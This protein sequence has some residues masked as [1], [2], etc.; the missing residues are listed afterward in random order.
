V[1]TFRDVMIG[2]WAQYHPQ[3]LVHRGVK[4]SVV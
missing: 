3:D 4:H 1:P 2:L